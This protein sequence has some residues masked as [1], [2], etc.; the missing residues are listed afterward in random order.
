MGNVSRE[1]EI[2]RKNKKEMLDMKNT[3]TVMKSAFDRLISR[4]NKDEKR[5]SAR[6]CI[7]RILEK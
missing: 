2:R 7:N 6:G 5:I 1:T 4:L 3:V